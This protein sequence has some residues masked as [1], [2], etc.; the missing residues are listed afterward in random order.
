MVGCS[1]VRRSRCWRCVTG[2]TASVRSHIPRSL[3]GSACAETL[4][5]GSI[6]AP[7]GS[8]AGECHRAFEEQHD[9]QASGAG[10]DTQEPSEVR[11]MALNSLPPIRCPWPVGMT[12]YHRLDPSRRP[13]I[14]TGWMLRTHGLFAAVLWAPCTE[15]CQHLVVELTT[16]VADLRGGTR[17]RDQVGGAS[18]PDS[19]MGQL[20]ARARPA[21]YGSRSVKAT[22]GSEHP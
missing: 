10:G 8:F 3:G 5:A 19:G 14:T 20:M 13:G 1:V 12:V 11:A 22:I 18:V 4:C 15:E 17:A 9:P 7:G 16:D 21:F 2:S 6:T